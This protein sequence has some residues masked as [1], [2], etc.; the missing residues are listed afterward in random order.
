MTPNAINPPEIKVLEPL[1]K[2]LDESIYS[3]WYKQFGDVP[4]SPGAGQV[5]CQD[6]GTG[7]Y[8]EARP[9]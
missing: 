7:T 6:D 1:R 2:E 3:D 5:E 9:G 4:T 8:A